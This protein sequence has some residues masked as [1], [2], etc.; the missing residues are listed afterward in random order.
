MKLLDGERALVTGAANGI[1]RGKIVRRHELMSIFEGGRH[2]PISILGLDITGEDVHDTGLIWD[3]GDGDLRAW[4]IPG[5]LVP[6]H[7]TNPPRGASW[8]IDVI[9]HI[10]FRPAERSALPS[11]DSSAAMPPPKFARTCAASSNWSKP[12]KSP[13]HMST[14]ASATT[15]SSAIS[16]APAACATHCA[17]RASSNAASHSARERWTSASLVSA[18]ACSVGSSLAAACE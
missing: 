2:M 11:R 14:F 1:G 15:A 18:I 8:R 7:G 12:A 17:R 16:F 9:E 6:L 4:P 5:T 10:N 3:T 13:R